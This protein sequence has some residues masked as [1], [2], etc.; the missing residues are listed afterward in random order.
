MKCPKCGEPMHEV[1]FD[2]DLRRWRCMACGRIY[3][4]WEYLT[5]RRGG[6][7]MHKVLAR[8]GAGEVAGENG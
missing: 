1:Y 5:W 7:V 4:L 2:D 6:D 8:D 3:V